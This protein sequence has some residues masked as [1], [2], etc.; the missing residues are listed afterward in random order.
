MSGRGRASGSDKSSA[1]RQRVY[2]N[3]RC[4]HTVGN[5]SYLSRRLNEGPESRLSANVWA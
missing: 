4:G 1:R 2:G 3:D 5:Y